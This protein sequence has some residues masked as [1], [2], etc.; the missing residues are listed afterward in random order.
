MV[1]N[2]NKKNESNNQQKYKINNIKYRK[3]RCAMFNEQS[4]WQ[5]FL[6]EIE[7]FHKNFPRE[8]NGSEPY[9]IF[10]LSRYSQ[11]N[12][13]FIMHYFFVVN[14]R[15]RDEIESLK[16]ELKKLKNQID[17]IRTWFILYHVLKVSLPIRY[18]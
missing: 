1:L 10:D 9:Q 12:Q 13:Y 14:S 18:Q 4:S 16:N 5:E 15:L 8:N 7:E 11:I 3:D 17:Y 6:D 2:K